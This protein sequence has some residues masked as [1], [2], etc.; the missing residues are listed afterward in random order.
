MLGYL[1]GLHYTVIDS[2]LNF[3]KFNLC[4]SNYFF[5]Y[6]LVDLSRLVVRL[7][8]YHIDLKLNYLNFVL[9]YF[10]LN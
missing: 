6:K 7:I 10:S 1:L 5:Y 8:Y 4:S 3:D 2:M 9:K